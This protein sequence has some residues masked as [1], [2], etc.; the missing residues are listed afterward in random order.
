M[1]APGTRLG[2]YEIM[3]LVGVGGMGEVYRAR[4]TKLGRDVAIKVLPAVVAADANRL[5]RFEREARVLASLNHPNIGA[6]YGLED[7]GAVRALVLELIEGPTLA[8]RIARSAIPLLETL[9][10]ARQIVDALEAAHEQGIVHRDLKPS[11]IKLRP[12]GT[13]KVLDF[14]LA[15]ALDPSARSSSA[16]EDLSGSGE[17]VA[18]SALTSPALMTGAGVLLGTAAYMSPEQARGYPVDK[19]ADVWAFGCV[20]Y[21]M[22]TGRRAFSGPT[23][24][25]MVAAIIEREPAF[26]RLPASTPPAIRRLLARCLEKDARRRLRDIGDARADMEDALAPASGGASGIARARWWNPAAAAAALIGT[27]AAAALIATTLTRRSA[28]PNGSGPVARLTVM[29]AEPLADVEEVVAVSPDGRRIA[30]VAG[31]ANRRR[32]FVREIDRYDSAPVPGTDG[33]DGVVFSDDGRSIAF[34][35]DRK[36]KTITLAGGSPVVAREPV[37][38]R[39]FDWTADGSILFNQATGTGVLRVRPE[40]ATADTVTRPAPREDQHRFPK[41]LP[42]GRAVLYSVWSGGGLADDEVFVHVLATG[43]RRALVKGTGA[44]FLPTGHL[45]Y[46]RGG[47]LFAVPFDPVK[48]E[49]KGNP[50]VVLQG[51]RQTPAGTPQLSVARDGTMVYV[52]GGSVARQ[53]T[54]VWL[55]RRGVEQPAGAFDRPIAQ[56]R[57]SPDGQRVAVVARGEPDVWQLDLTRD[58]WT[59]V[60]FDGSSAFPLWRSDG[61]LTFSSGKAGPYNIYLKNT[62]AS[63]SEERLF[64][65]ARSSYPLSWSPDGRLL[66]FVSINAETGNDIWLFD[67]TERKAPRPFLASPFAEGAPV[68]SP[69]GRHMAYVSNESGRPEIYLQPI[70]RP[71]EKLIVSAGGGVEPVWPRNSRELFYRSGN[72]IMAVDVTVG[73]TLSAGKPREVF[74]R[75]FERTTAFWANYDVDNQGQRFL[76]LKG[77][78]A[79][80][81]PAEIRVVINW[82][83]E[84]KARVPIK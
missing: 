51:V 71:G 24:S 65:V 18:A 15:K 60:T 80:A 30:Y 77:A 16:V 67:A 56:P 21:E 62:D 23:A 74:E 8:D 70:D 22:L 35:A 48:L 83:E 64:E 81:A 82:F 57:L 53:G 38:G 61:R 55:D 79:P 78:T 84:L 3:S 49:L 10:I 6:I 25:D 2:S 40:S 34:L 59:R 72:A 1:I 7:S 39:G 50:I 5:S 66:A 11:N 42:D 4:D 9:S 45:V 44:Q 13:V 43:E 32:I 76:M 20:L 52:T 73:R 41:Q 63:G 68:F 46:V 14:G 47:S 75:N 27:A 37:L 28:A 19:R 12:D 29:P 33:A 58:A 17:T 31:T 69:D 36:L 54:L 26:D